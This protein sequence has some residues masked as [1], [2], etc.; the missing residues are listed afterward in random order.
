M[1]VM[2]DTVTQKLPTSWPEREEL[3]EKGQFWT[4]AWLAQTMA[5]W[6]TSHKPTILFDP[7][8]G[9]GT[10]FAAARA[11]GYQGSF[12]GFE[13]HPDVLAEH[14]RSL[15]SAKDFKHVQ[16]TDFIKSPVKKPFSAII[17]NP[18]YI[19]HHR[20]TTKDKEELRHLAI[21]WLGFPLD[22]RV[23]LHL[24]FLLKSLEL[25]APNG[26]LAFL[27]P[28]SVCEG[29][30]S[31]KV[32]ENICKRFRLDAVLTFTQTA[33]PFPRVD[34]NAMVFLLSRRE[35]SS[36]FRW[37][38]VNECDP[39]KIL[40]SLNSEE[41]DDLCLNR[42]LPEALNTG[43]SRPPMQSMQGVFLSSAAK[44]VR[45]IA[46]GANEFF[47]LSE[48][49]ISELGLDKSYFIRAIGRT[50][51]CTSDILKPDHFASLEKKGRA[52]WLLNLSHEQPEELPTTLKN[53]LA[54]GEIQGFHKR[55]LISMRKPWYKMERRSPPALLFS[56]L[57]RR[58]CRFILNEAGVVPL[59]GFLCVYPFNNEPHGVQKLWR[60]LNHPKTTANL[61]FTAKS[62]GSGALKAE[63]RQLDKLLIPHSVIEEV[64]LNTDMF[65]QG[66]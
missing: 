40:N 41:T 14:D 64:G 17:S 15:L 26:R 39:K 4:P 60:A 25:L 2:I 66:E 12:A 50:K 23:G 16:F 59:T 44:I 42:D 9:P 36:H 53:Y 5:A 13:L 52:S 55:A 29:V 61:E 30:S 58:D 65:A 46:T 24:Y 33:A 31:K 56:Y 38:K 63:P 48:K 57:G 10:F 22:G 11:T 47:F 28:A 7:A 45:G 18:P 1:S 6:V 20:L 35:P 51:D 54:E 3:R 43:L 49:Q 8:V 27:L 32:W 62:Y 34:T 21:E 19:R 37:I